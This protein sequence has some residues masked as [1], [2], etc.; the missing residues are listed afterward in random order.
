MLDADDKNLNKT[1]KMIGCR[2]QFKYANC[3]TKY[4]NSHLDKVLF[5]EVKPTDIYCMLTMCQA[6]L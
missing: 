6:L 1:W 3:N 5:S 2:N 4:Y